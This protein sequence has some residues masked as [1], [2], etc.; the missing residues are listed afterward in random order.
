MRADIQ[1]TP[2]LS[3]GVF[4]DESPFRPLLLQ[5]FY[6]ILTEKAAASGCGW[7]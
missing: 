3:A 6:G 4:F 1:K 7:A 5:L 2:A